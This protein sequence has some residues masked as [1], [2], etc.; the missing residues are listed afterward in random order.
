MACGHMHVRLLFRKWIKQWIDRIPCMSVRVR[1]ISC[2][3]QRL[4]QG[5]TWCF[6]VRCA[7]NSFCCF[8]LWQQVLLVSRLLVILFSRSYCSR[9]GYVLSHGS[10]G[11]STC[12]AWVFAFYISDVTSIV[13]YLK[14]GW[15]FCYSKFS[16]PLRVDA[17]GRQAGEATT[18]LWNM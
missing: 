17:H 8:L 11:W 9:W 16:V 1:D 10:V 5:L 13:L 18:E 3:Y 4:C 14:S 2:F 6:E 15:S 7:S 12:S